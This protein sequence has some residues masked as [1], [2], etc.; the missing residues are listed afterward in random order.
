M[1]FTLPISHK[2]KVSVINRVVAKMIDILIVF[3]VAAIL[4][5]PIGPLG[6]FMF[7]LCAD[8]LNIGPFQGQS[9][10]KKIMGLQVWST[11]SKR[12]A[13]MRDSM[14]R[15]TPVGVATF[16]AIIPVW[17]WL[18]LGIVGIPLVV[19]EVYLMVTM[20][21]GHR[22]GDVMGDTEVRDLKNQED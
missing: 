3:L 7:S 18:I 12:P 20:E 9:V 15:N 6:G 8:G 17:G 21:S 19:M 16:F 1:L 2:V 14:I 4:P 10:G 5:Y 22:L 11:V 13:H